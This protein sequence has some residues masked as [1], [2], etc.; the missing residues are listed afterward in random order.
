MKIWYETPQDTPISS[1]WYFDQRLLSF[2]QYF[3]SD[4]DYI[5]FARSVYEQQHFR[6]SIKFAMY[7]IKPGAIKAGTVKVNFKGTIER[8]V[9]R[10]NAFLFMYSVNG[11]PAHWKQFGIIQTL[12]NA[13]FG[14]NPSPSP[15]VTVCNVSNM[16]LPLLRNKIFD[17]NNLRYIQRDVLTHNLC[18]FT[19]ILLMNIVLTVPTFAKKFMVIQIIQT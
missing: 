6:S 7:K 15:L 14:K 1:A 11:T 8:F 12:G 17:S 10:D 3:S 13:V 4:A 2:N 5:F 16:P 18:G 9:A 19:A